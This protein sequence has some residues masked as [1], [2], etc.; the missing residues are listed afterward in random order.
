[1]IMKLTVKKEGYNCYKTV[2]LNNMAG[3]ENEGNEEN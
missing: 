1:M 3:F 2:S